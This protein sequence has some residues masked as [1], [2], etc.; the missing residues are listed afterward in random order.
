MMHTVKTSL[1][2]AATGALLVLTSTQSFAVGPGSNLGYVEEARTNTGLIGTSTVPHSSPVTYA[3]RVTI[4]NIPTPSVLSRSTAGTAQVPNGEWVNGYLQ[5]GFEILGPK[6]VVVPI[7]IAGIIELSFDSRFNA[8]T[9]QWDYHSNSGVSIQVD[10]Y[11][12]DATFLTQSY[13]GSTCSIATTLICEQGSQYYDYI[14]GVAEYNDEKRM[15]LVQDSSTSSSWAGHYYGTIYVATGSS[16]IGMGSVSLTSAVE[17]FREPWATFPVAF[18]ASAFID[19][20]M[21]IDAVWLAQH[22]GTTLTLPPGIGNSVGQVPEPQ[23]SMLMLIGAALLMP[24]AT[25]RRRSS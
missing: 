17:T 23:T 5:Y 19:P 11:D 25:R 13:A 3:D 7:K 18:Q 14:N 22:P 6:D 15:T 1:L 8:A 16:G 10:T 20:I 9:E 24:L 21:E 2:S 4:S 12:I